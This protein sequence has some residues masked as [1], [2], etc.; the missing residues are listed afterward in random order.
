MW[1][2]YCGSPAR[3]N[4]CLAMRNS[5]LSTVLRTSCRL[6]DLLLPLYPSA[7]RH[8]F[9]QDM[10]DVFEQQ[11]RGECGQHGLSGLARVWSSVASEIIWYAVPR[12][13]EWKRIGVPVVSLLATIFLFE[14]I[15]RAMGVVTHCPK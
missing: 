2:R 11:I 15:L 3:R 6:Y 12:E 14:G 5:T 4:W 10:A 13:F 8:Q 9:G 7:L 1:A